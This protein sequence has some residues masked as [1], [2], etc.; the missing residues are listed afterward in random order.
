MGVG[1]EGRVKKMGMR[2]WDRHQLISRA[3]K[4]W[5]RGVAVQAQVQ[6][7]W[8]QAKTKRYRLTTT[9]QKTNASPI[10]SHPPATQ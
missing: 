5:V 6:D 9:T 3:D 8:D 7:Q 4:R 2:S 10:P 1:A